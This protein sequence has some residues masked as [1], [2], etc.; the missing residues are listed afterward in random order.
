MADYDIYVLDESDITL[1][2]G[3]ILDGVNQGD[4]SHLLGIEIT[5][6][7]NAW[8]PISITDDDDN[9]QDSDNSQ[10][11]DGAQTV[12]G[13]TYDSGTT[14]EAE[15]SF[16][17]TDGTNSWT[18]VAFNV[19][20]S[21]PAYGTVEGLAFVGDPGNF[22][23]V[24]VTL[25]VTSTLEGPS[26]D[27]GDYTTPICF[28]EG[29]LIDTP[30]GPCPIETIASG[31]LMTTAS[32]VAMPVRWRGAR[33]VARKG[34]FASVV[35]APGAIGNTDPLETSQ[36]HRV[37]VTGWKAELLFGAPEV[38]VAAIHLVND[39]SV[40]LRHGGCVSYHHLLLDSHQLVCAGGA[41]TETLLPGPEALHSMT[42]KARKEVLSLF[43]E[44]AE[45]FQRVDQ[46]NCAQSILPV[47]KS[48]EVRSFLP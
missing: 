22:P 24:G 46:K 25:T 35:F 29:T 31:D 10:R 30:D 19:N 16:V 36:Q 43:P 15:F 32:G 6:N 3:A 26:F 14:V 45:K 42:P 21:N 17:V 13:V 18:L 5:L 1:S 39:H 41:W 37:L 27:S 38:L 28:A 44:L 12:D 4:G 48:H 23:P 8:R 20:N 11:L 7:D 2:D 33:R 9:F 47:L 34:P 40:R